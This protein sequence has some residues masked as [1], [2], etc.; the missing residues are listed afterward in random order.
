VASRRTFRLRHRGQDEYRPD[1][2]VVDDNPQI[3][4]VMRATLAAQGYEVS[5]SRTGEAALERLRSATY[6]LVLPDMNIPG[7]GGIEGLACW[8]RTPGAGTLLPARIDLPQSNSFMNSLGFVYA[9]F[10]RCRVP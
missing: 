4:R 5:D 8:S 2:L 10:R 9:L 3:C 6:N 1:T 7:M